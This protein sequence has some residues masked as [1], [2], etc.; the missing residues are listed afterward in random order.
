M[1]AVDCSIVD[2]AQVGVAPILAVDAVVVDNP[3]EEHETGGGGV[4]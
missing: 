4:D 2:V 3:T 1:V